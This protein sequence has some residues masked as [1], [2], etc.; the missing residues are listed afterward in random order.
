V[1]GLFLAGLSAGYAL[2]GAV[3]RRIV[4]R[5]ARR[6][7]PAPLLRVYGLVEAG[8]GGFALAFPLA[9]A[10]VQRASL[11]LPITGEATAFAL[12]V[13]LSAV[14]VLPSTLLMGGTVPLLTQGLSRS[15]EDAT[16]FHAFVYAFNTA[17][18]FVGALAGGFVLLPW[19]GLRNVMLAMGAINVCVGGVFFWLGRDRG[20]AEPVDGSAPP[21]TTGGLAPLIAIALLCGFAA[22]AIQ[23]VWNRMAAMS[24][25]SSPYTFTLVVALFVSCIALGSLLVSLL[26]RIGGRWLVWNLALL[27][28]WFAGLH[29]LMDSTPIAAHLLRLRFG[30]GVLS[31]YAFWAGVLGLLLL[32]VGPGVVLSGATLPCSS[33]AKERHG[34]LGG[35]AGRLYAWNTVGSLAGALI[36]GHLLLHWLDLDAVHQAALAALALAFAISVARMGR[37]GAAALA[38]VAS[39][40]LVLALPHWDP[41]ALSLGLFRA[42]MRLPAPSYAPAAL[43]DWFY[44]D[45][46][47]LFYDDDPIAS[48]AVHE[49]TFRGERQRAI[50]TNGKP[51]G[52]TK[53]DYPTMALAALLPALHAPH[54]ERAFVIGWGTGVTAGE[55]T[56]LSTTRE[57]AVAEI[58]SAVLAA[59]P[60]FA[61]ANLAAGASPKLRRIRSD[62]Y[63]ALLRGNAQFDA[64]VS[65]PSN[66]WM[67]GVEMLFSREFLEAAKSRLA[68]G[69]VYV[70][71]FHCY[72]S[73]D[74]TLA[75]VLRTFRSVFAE[76][77]VWY[78]FGDDLLLLGFPEPRADL[79]PAA[80]AE[81]MARPDLAAGLARAGV[82]SVAE[83]I[84]H[85]LLPRGVLAE[86]ELPGP[87]HTLLHP[88]LTY[89]AARAFFAGGRSRPP[90]VTA[91]PAG[92]L[93][94]Q[95]S[96][97]RKLAASEGGELSETSYAAL[98]DETALAR[99]CLHRL[100][101]GPAAHGRARRSSPSASHAGARRRSV[102]RS[103][104]TTR[105]RSPPC[106]R[107]GCRQAQCQP[108]TLHVITPPVRASRT[109]GI[110]S[111]AAPRSRPGAARRAS[112][113]R[114]SS[115][116]GLAETIALVGEGRAGWQPAEA[117]RAACD[118]ERPPR[119]SASTRDRAREVETPRSRRR[120][121]A[122]SSAFS[123]P[124]S[125]TSAGPAAPS[126]SSMA[127]YEGSEP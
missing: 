23:T 91:G 123:S 40:G 28:L 25:G 70:Q 102:S 112:A 59:D 27:L 53:G 86:L 48:I 31:F 98:V 47:L 36:G 89:Q 8:I 54:L 73:D 75:L 121:S 20:Q 78:T 95:R 49:F 103:R 117:L 13:A 106:S 43:L 38:G 56:A 93:A 84:A 122:A 76:T 90:L 68:P 82:E 71:W 113:R 120:A 88:R 19:L 114:R 41:R 46:A 21:R 44:R 100:A 64:I 57:V 45:R 62:A 18:A 111:T 52:A 6:G 87:L 14:L 101:R 50:L 77:S 55:L 34:D 32:V 72:E 42:R 119:G 12:D 118:I 127:R 92:A 65:E 16:R 17:G 60:F 10:G 74:A 124:A 125:V 3:S 108:P 37:R 115:E 24:F 4:E 116:R 79:S 66:P 1:L 105:A 97:A 104:R 11:A 80:L 7:E 22:M 26:P 67:A 96:L 2:F 51:D 99:G 63:R 29:L 15:M 126:R 69:G 107:A 61:S 81:R 35:V 5:A 9:F 109:A 85:E 58:S 110:P 83:L 39:L 30:S 94:A 33:T